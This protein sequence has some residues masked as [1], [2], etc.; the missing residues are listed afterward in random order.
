MWLCSS[1]WH[2]SRGA[3]LSGLAI[4]HC[5]W[6]SMLSAAPPD[7]ARG[8]PGM[9]EPQQGSSGPWITMWRMTANIKTGLFHKREGNSDC[10]RALKHGGL[11]VTAVS[12]TLTDTD[13]EG[14]WENTKKAASRYWRKMGL[15][16]F[17]WGCQGCSGDVG[18]S[19]EE[20][21]WKSEIVL[22]KKYL[23]ISTGYKPLA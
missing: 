11:F 21:E 3:S 8:A 19:R 13:R 14:E 16:G 10:V 17:R 20:L 22:L 7:G 9:E 2:M 6:F 15:E 12:L 18:V 5:A 4:N 23:K 1:Q